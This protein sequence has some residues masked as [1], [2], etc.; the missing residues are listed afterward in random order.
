MS[1]Y[2]KMF[3]RLAENREGA[4]IPFLMLGDPDAETCLARI[5]A[6][7]AAGADALE[8]GLPFSDPVADGPTLVEAA[9]RALANGTTPAR[10]F[11]M[12]GEIRAR[13]PDI[14]V[15]LLVYAN[16]VLARGVDDF[17]ARAARAG[18]DSILVPD[19]PLRE[20]RP[21]QEAGQRHGIEPV[22]ILP[23]DANDDCVQNVAATSRGYV[24]V[25]GRKGVTGSERAA[26]TPLPEK[27]Q[28]LRERNAAPAVIGFGVS[29]AA[30]VR[31]ALDAGASGAIV[32][33]A[34]VK[35]FAAGEDGTALVREL[36]QATRHG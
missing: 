6:V 18:V 12:L 17:F 10:C 26:E 33:S 23:P 31:N 7:I 30:H 24:Y 16:L 4:L 28:A 22:F 1:R 32:G 15:G 29:S 27:L 11:E 3:Q 13:H 34:L 20:S 25:L 9:N 19:M 21:L 14:P 36:K 5:D 35:T 8:L 2:T